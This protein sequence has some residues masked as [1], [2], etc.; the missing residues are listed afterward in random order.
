CR[1]ARPRRAASKC[2]TAP[3]STRC[4]TAPSSWSSS[5]SS[6]SSRTSRATAARP[7]P[8]HRHQHRHRRQQQTDPRRG[9]QVEHNGGTDEIV[10]PPLLCSP[11]W[12]KLRLWTQ[13]RQELLR[14]VDRKST[15]LNSSHLVI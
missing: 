8:P 15:R 14:L 2:S 11:C 3:R 7:W 4:T 6:A 10:R 5:A 9:G 13:S 12:P 1:T